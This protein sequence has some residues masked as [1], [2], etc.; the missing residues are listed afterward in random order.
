MKTIPAILLFAAC[1]AGAGELDFST[2]T[3]KDVFLPPP[4]YGQNIRLMHNS[5]T[6]KKA[7]LL[8]WDSGKKRG[9]NCGCEKRRNWGNSIGLTQK[10]T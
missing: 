9:W 7:W 1:S 6:G 8:R 10:S 5:A 4:Q 2:L 3:E